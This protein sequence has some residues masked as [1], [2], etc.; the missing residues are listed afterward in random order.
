MMRTIFTEL[1]IY[2]E[3]KNYVAFDF[4]KDDPFLAFQR[5]Y[6]PNIFTPSPAART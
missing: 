4:Q 3:D 5:K 2:D 6:L 1:H